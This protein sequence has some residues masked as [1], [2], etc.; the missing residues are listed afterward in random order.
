MSEA[1]FQQG[2]GSVSSYRDLR[3]PKCFEHIHVI[4]DF[5]KPLCDIVNWVNSS[6][7]LPAIPM[8]CQP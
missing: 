4:A 6:Q 5:A 8:E 3:S 7:L 2:Q 1:R